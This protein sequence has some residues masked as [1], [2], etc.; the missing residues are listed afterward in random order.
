VATCE[1]IHRSKLSALRGA[2]KWRIEGMSQAEF[3][4]IKVLTEYKKWQRCEHSIQHCPCGKLRK[5]TFDELCQTC[6]RKAQWAMAFVGSGITL[7][8]CGR[9]AK[10]KKKGKK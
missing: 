9:C 2:L 3:K 1:S 6:G 4:H 10:G 5:P 7:Y 8:A